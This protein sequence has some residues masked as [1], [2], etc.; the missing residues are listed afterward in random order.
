MQ[1]LQWSPE[2]CATHCMTPVVTWTRGNT[3][4]RRE[5]SSTSASTR[6]QREMQ[7]KNC[8]LATGWAA[9]CRGSAGEG[10]EKAPILLRLQ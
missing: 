10:S 7:C 2:Q 3:R 8:Q 9:S 1:S 5:V 6:L 4:G